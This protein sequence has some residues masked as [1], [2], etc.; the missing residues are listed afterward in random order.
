M[1]ESVIPPN[2]DCIMLA[3]NSLAITLLNIRSFPKHA[4]DIG[5]SEMLLQTDIFCFT[6]AQLLLESRNN[7]YN[8]RE[9]RSV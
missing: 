7:R 3:D 8:F 6:E 1:N 5:D 9:L 2:A 4:V